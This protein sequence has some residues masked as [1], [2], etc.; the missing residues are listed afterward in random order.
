MCVCLIVW[1]DV[2]SVQVVILSGGLGFCGTF[3]LLAILHFF[4]INSHLVCKTLFCLLCE[5][6]MRSSHM[7]SDFKSKQK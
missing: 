6:G 2:I 7:C 4:P 5:N 1:L 3:V